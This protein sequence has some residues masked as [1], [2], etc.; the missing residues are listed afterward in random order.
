MF[1]YTPDVLNITFIFDGYH[2][3]STALTPVQ[4]NID[5]RNV[6][7]IFAK[8]KIYFATKLTSG[9]LVTPVLTGMYKILCTYADIYILK[10]VFHQVEGYVAKWGGVLPLESHLMDI[11]AIYREEDFNKYPENNNNLYIL[12][13]HD[14]RNN[15]HNNKHK[16]HN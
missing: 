9:D 14:D 16:W 5:I 3:S 7:G 1:F 12:E 15:W 8:S 2:C 11:V 10:V 4:Y 6:I 13:F